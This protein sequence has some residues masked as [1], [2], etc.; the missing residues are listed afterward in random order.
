MLSCAARTASHRPNRSVS[1]AARRAGRAAGAMGRERTW[2]ERATGRRPTGCRRPGD[3][4]GDESS[5]SSSSSSSASAAVHCLGGD[6]RRAVGLLVGAGA[7][8]LR[9][10]SS[11]G[12][13]LCSSSARAVQRRNTRLVAQQR[14]DGPHALLLGPLVRRQAAHGGARGLDQPAVRRCQ[15]SAACAGAA[16]T[17]R[18][19]RSTP[20]KSMACRPRVR[21]VRVGTMAQEASNLSARASARR[22]PKRRA[23]TIAAVEHDVGSGRDETRRLCV[24]ALPADAVSSWRPRSGAPRSWPAQLRNRCRGHATQVGWQ[25][26]CSAG[27]P[28]RVRRARQRFART[29]NRE[30][31]IE[32]AARLDVVLR[33]HTRYV[34]ACTPLARLAAS[35]P[36]RCRLWPPG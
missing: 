13:A 1:C 4:I 2:S 8:G 6:T 16:R 7:D 19:G 31:P 24:V 15:R 5:P 28:V 35:A 10:P 30:I 29:Q 33:T 14:R 26:A 18:R 25:V 32:I 20:R 21:R 11:R 3:A 36:R 27:G 34:P 9:S 12:G 23:G 17:H 22:P